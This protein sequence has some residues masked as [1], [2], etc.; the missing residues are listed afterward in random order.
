M[1]THHGDPGH[2]GDL[3][4]ELT[5]AREAADEAAAIVRASYL[6]PTR[7]RRKGAHDV[8]TAIDVRAER[9]IMH[10]LRSAFP[11][12][13]RIGE[14]SGASGGRTD[15]AH[16]RSWLV[17]PLDGTVNF[18]AGVPF[19]SVSIALV[20]RGRA[21]IGIVV[22]PL[23]EERFVGVTGSGAWHEPSLAALAARR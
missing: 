18:A 19:F 13:A 1:T 12:D 10:R 9:A 4:V 7:R 20:E 8:V 11:C 21:L 6:R 5:V 15:G 14:E 3:G 16:G 22:D 17:D 23:T 2:D